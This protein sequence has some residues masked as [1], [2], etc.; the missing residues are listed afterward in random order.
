[1]IDRCFWSNSIEEIMDALRRE[2]HP[3]AKEILQKMECNSMLSMK[4]A[5][6]M[7]RKA[8]NMGYGEILKMELN[9]ALNK[10]EDSD[11][12]LGVKEVLMKPTK[13]SRLGM[14]PNPG[15]KTEV[16]DLELESYFREN[17]FA[18][19]IDL[20]I[21][22]NSLLPTRHFFERFSDSMRVYINETS[23]P[24]EEIRDAVR[25]EIEENLRAQG[26]DIRD[27]TV[28]IPMAREYIDKKLKREN[29][30]AE[31][32]RRSEQLVTDKKLRQWYFDGINQELSKLE[33]KKGFYSLVNE[34]IH[35][36][37]EQA[38]FERLNMVYEKSKEAQS[39][40][41]R[42]MF[43]KMK[44]FLIKSRIMGYLTEESERLTKQLE[45][46]PFKMI[47]MTEKWDQSYRDIEHPELQKSVMYH[48]SKV[49][50]KASLA[51]PEMVKTFLTDPEAAKSMQVYTFDKV[52][53]EKLQKDIM[54]NP[55]KYEQM[56]K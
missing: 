2:T 3:F 6:K 25:I 48:L 37:F 34:K 41:K 11:F 29:Q 1:M 39:L 4:L 31:L 32:M 7:L 9:V 30:L 46:L 40:E 5:L 8:K 56:L 35:K 16:S 13:I 33:D 19:K 44:K 36:I 52:E 18:S 21:V 51:P 14:R 42:R 10:T 17:K 15:F 54:S 45:A 49:V 50:G 26:I 27:K 12:E 28:T 47:H 55:E 22:E 38:Y 23:S 20:D 43:I 24:Q 53:L